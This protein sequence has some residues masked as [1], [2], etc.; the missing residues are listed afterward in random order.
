M[1]SML[2]HNSALSLTSMLEAFMPFAV[3]FIKLTD[4]VQSRSQFVAVEIP[5]VVLIF[6]FERRL[7]TQ[8]QTTMNSFRTRNK[9]FDLLG[10]FLK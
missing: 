5:T 10:T 9:R 4:L 2:S 7:L 6:V 3:Y 1:I 8:R